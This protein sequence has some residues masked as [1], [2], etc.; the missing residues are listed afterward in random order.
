MKNLSTPI[1]FVGYGR[2]TFSPRPACS[3]RP[4]YPLSSRTDPSGK[5]SIGRPPRPLKTTHVRWALKTAMAQN[6]IGKAALCEIEYQKSRKAGVG[7]Q[8]G[9]RRSENHRNKNGIGKMPCCKT[10]VPKNGAMK[11]QGIGRN[12]DAL[13]SKNLLPKIPLPQSLL[14]RKL[15]AKN[16]SATDPIERIR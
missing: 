3:N 10:E 9:R 8:K 2:G 4:F 11:K 5:M 7:K 1:T 14:P 16:H 13:L 15:F 12:A 6:E